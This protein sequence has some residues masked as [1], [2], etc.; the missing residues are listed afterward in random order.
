MYICVV[1][2]SNILELQ[3]YF[4]LDLE[5]FSLPPY[6]IN[7]TPLPSKRIC[8]CFPLLIVS[9]SLRGGCKKFEV[10]YSLLEWLTLQLGWGTDSI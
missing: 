8:Q 9:L 7:S 3:K 1:Y 10:E 5:K 6:P 4:M 2:F